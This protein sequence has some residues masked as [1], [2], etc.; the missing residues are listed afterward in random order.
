MKKKKQSIAT[1][2][3]ISLLAISLLGGTF[4]GGWQALT[5]SD[6][7]GGS[8]AGQ[9]YQSQISALDQQLKESPEDSSIQLSLA[10]AYYDYGSY[11]LQ[12]DKT[13]EGVKQFKLAIP[14]YQKVVAKEK[15]INAYVDLA[16]AALYAGEDEVAETGFKEALAINPKFYTALYN[17]GVFLAQSKLDYN[18]AIEQFE[19]AKAVA[20]STEEANSLADLIASY[21]EMM[22]QKAMNDAVEGFN[23]DNP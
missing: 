2:I 9:N 17:Y 21:Q 15:N 7:G 4:Y 6:L 22:K 8:A 11:L 10:N 14:L 1:W 5:A 20:P 13:E 23:S 18:G 12:N 19:A 16:T 3:I